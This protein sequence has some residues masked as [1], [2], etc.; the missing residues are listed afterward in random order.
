MKWFEKF[1]E[2]FIIALVIAGIIGMLT[3]HFNY[4]ELI[5]NL[6]LN[7]GSK[8]LLGPPYVLIILLTVGIYL[9]LSVLFSG[10]I[11]WNRDLG[12]VCKQFRFLSGVSYFASNGFATYRFVRK[13]GVLCIEICL[14]NFDLNFEDEIGFTTSADCGIILSKSVN[15]KL[16]P[17]GFLISDKKKMRFEIMGK[18][19][20]EQIG[21][22]FKNLQ[23]HEQKY[24]LSKFLEGGIEKGVWKIVEIDLDEYAHITRGAHEKVY[25]ENFSIFTNSK[26]SGSNEQVV[27]IRNIEFLTEGQNHN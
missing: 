5:S 10:S 3:H 20:G 27:Y 24:T 21:L 18:E 25:L 4:L 23:G 2:D 12:Q 26:L 6:S 1:M 15:H 17:K 14:H 13:G 8:V 16:L 9:A 22:A 7:T 11:I 19:G